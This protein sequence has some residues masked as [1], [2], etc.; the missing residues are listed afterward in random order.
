MTELI[1]PIHKH[2]KDL[3]I[4]DVKPSA[5]SRTSSSIISQILS[6]RIK[7]HASHSSI[8]KES[9][10]GLVVGE[11][12][13]RGEQVVLHGRN[14]CH[15]NLREVAHLVLSQTEISLTLLKDDFQRPALGVDSVGLKEVYL[16]VGG[17]ESVP[18]SPLAA[19]TEKQTDI[20]T[21]EA[22][23]HSD[24]PAS[25]TTAVFASLLRVVEESNK[26]VG[27]CITP[28]Y[29]LRL[30]HFDHTKVMA[31]DVAGSDEKDD[32]GTGKPTVGQHVV[33][34]DLALDDATYHLNHQ[35]NLA[36][37]VFLDAPGSVRVTVA[38][39]GETG[40]QLL[41]LQAVISLLA[42]LRRQWQ[43]RAASGSCHL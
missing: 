12:S 4:L 8:L 18:L 20:A 24:V 30:A 31:S 16:A 43:S 35:R 33:E 21:S 37:V 41:L 5:I 36:L 38:L 15:G 27:R 40:I 14:G 22:H 25:Q 26:L 6:V 2:I 11:T 10:N 1:R 23:V 17:D 19:L 3:F 29:V 42:C 13:C 9:A 34:V 39:L 7:F 32:L 28:L